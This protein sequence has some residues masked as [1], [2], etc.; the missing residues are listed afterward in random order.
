MSL[1]S[2]G[3]AC[4]RWADLVQVPYTRRTNGSHQ[5]QRG[6]V[7]DSIGKTRRIAGSLKAIVS[8]SPAS[9]T[10]SGTVN[11]LDPSCHL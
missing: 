10:R 5:T 3:V 2:R 1:D 11:P 8:V 9:C 7:R 4:N 6:N